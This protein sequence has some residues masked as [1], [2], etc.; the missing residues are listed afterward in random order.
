MTNSIGDA[1]DETLAAAVALASLPEMGPGRL[2]AVTFVH[3]FDEAWERVRAGR[4]LD[5]PT[6]AR[7]LGTK[8]QSVID[9]WRQTAR[10]IDPPRLLDAHRQAGIDIHILGDPGYPALLATDIEPPAVL[11]TRGDLSALDGTRVAIVGTR[12]CTQAGRLIARD[13]GHDLAAEG[14]KVVSGLALGIDGAAHE[15]ALR[16]NVP[17]SA[18]GVVGTG[19]DTIY[20]KRHRALWEALAEQG[21]LLSEVPLGGEGF[22]WRFP[23]RNR[24]I[25]ALADLVVVV[26]SHA[27]GGALHTADEAIRRD[28]PVMAVPGS[29]RSPASAG[30]NGLLFDGIGP[31]RDASDIM[32]A[33]GFSPRVQQLDLGET[34]GSSPS[35]RPVPISQSTTSPVPSTPSPSIDPG[36]Q[37]ILDQIDSA[38]ISV[39]QLSI[40]SG[41]GLAELSVALVKLED[42]GLVVRSGS[43]VERVA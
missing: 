38:A 41:L 40:G 5:H 24:V 8:P 32:A 9:T 33:L 6:I 2:T 35:G 31:V 37:T 12:R 1:S 36:L 20:P 4:G 42:M 13:L 3:G 7:S 10:S 14:I 27:S 19:L 25:A 11:F 43:W 15:G 26:E 28:V 39:D 23:A 21:L 17:L 16:A 22:R 34:K 30:T 29:V 18:V